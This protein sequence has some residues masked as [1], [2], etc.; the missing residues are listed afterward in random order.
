MSDDSTLIYTDFTM[1]CPN[2][3]PGTVVFKGGQ[4]QPHPCSYEPPAGVHVEVTDDVSS[5]EEL[6]RRVTQAL[7]DAETLGHMDSSD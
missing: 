2:C 6:A 7:D 3:G 1:D 5:E 4:R